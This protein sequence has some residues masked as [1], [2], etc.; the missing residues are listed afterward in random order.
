MLHV[1][2][3]FTARLVCQVCLQSD[4]HN[5]TAALRRTEKITCVFL[6]TL[7][8]TIAAGC[9]KTTLARAAAGASGMRLQVLSGAQ[10]FSMYVG[11]GEGLLRAA[12]Q[13]ARMTAPSIL[14]IDEIDAIVGAC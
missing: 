2:S 9:S 13:R 4:L 3:F 11:E 6:A 7:P 14:F 10:L 12:F 1:E 8:S 5:T